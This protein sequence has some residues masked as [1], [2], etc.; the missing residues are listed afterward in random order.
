MKKFA[1]T[2]LALTN[3]ALAHAQSNVTV[4]G[5]LDLGTWYQSKTA[6]AA[7]NT[8]VG[9]T[10]SVNTG[11][12]SPSVFGLKGT[13]DL[14]GGLSAT[15]NLESH[16]D[17]STGATGL[18]SLWAR[19]ANVGLTGDWGSVK[20]GQQLVPALIGFA[21]TDPRGVRESLS[22]TQV[23]A[24]SSGQNAGPGSAVPNSTFAFF[25]S[26]ALS[27]SFSNA[28]LYLGA[29]YAVGE[30]SG[31]SSANR[32]ISLG[33]SYS[34]PLILSGSFHESNWASTGEKSD[35]K[36]SVGAGMPFGSAVAKINYLQTKAYMN[37]GVMSGDYRILS[38]GGEYQTSA[39][40]TV[41]A[42]YY[43]GKNHLPGAKDDKANS[44][45]VSDEYSLSKRTT[46]YAQVAAI[47][48]GDGA[49]T[50]VAVL[51]SQPVQGATTYVGNIG[52]RHR[53]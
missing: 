12:L 52:I 13:E 34:G 36:V 10:S 6:G 40:N 31:N 47:N 41:T 50:P 39:T 5:V 4:Y 49:S 7:L 2:A 23:W 45:V 20:V 38:V 21:A 27:Y 9:S 43:R 33:A 18:G 30:V 25:A 22:G 24:S 16:L 37:T 51:G 48:A 29:L 46:L 32:V 44:F 11:G 8:S 53:F 17:P 19:A 28:G 35:R 14:G 15:F 42:G 26:N 3:C 1:L